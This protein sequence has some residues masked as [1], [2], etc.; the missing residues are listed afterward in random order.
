MKKLNNDW[1]KYYKRRIH[2]HWLCIKLRRWRKVWYKL[3][4]GCLPTQPLTKKELENY[5]LTK[6]LLKDVKKDLYHYLTINY[7][8]QHIYDLVKT[9]RP[10]SKSNKQKAL[11]MLISTI[12]EERTT[13]YLFPLLAKGVNLFDIYKKIKMV[14]IFFPS[15]RHWKRKVEVHKATF[16]KVWFEWFR[17]LWLL[18]EN[19][20]NEDTQNTANKWTE[21]TVNNKR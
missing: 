6:F 3:L 8:T 18:K 10:I 1:N 11:G 15:V 4:D 17:Q 21:K 16:L 7:K 13:R 12:W 5:L 20:N 2:H 14:D 19:I 9:N